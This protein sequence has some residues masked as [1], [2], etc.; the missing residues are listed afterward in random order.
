MFSNFGLGG[1]GGQQQ[2]YQQ[3]PYYQQPSVAMAMPMP[4][5]QPFSSQWGMPQQTRALSSVE[6]KESIDTWFNSTKAMIRAIP[7]Y[8]RYMDL[9]WQ[10]HASDQNRGFED[11]QTDANLT[12][13]VQS[14]Q[15][16]ALIDLCCTTVPEIDIN[17]VRAE[18]TSLLWIYNYVREHYGV[19]RT[20]RQMMQKFGVLQRRSGERLN[21]FWTRFQG[22]YAEN[23]IRKNDEIKISDNTGKLITA[24]RDEQGERYRLSSDIVTCLYLAHPDLP[25]EVEKMLSGKLENQDVASLQKEIFVKANIILEQLDRNP[26][27]NRTQVSQN[28]QPPRPRGLSTRTYQRTQR[29]NGKTNQRP[30]KPEHYC[31]SCLRSQ[32]NKDQ[33]NSH[34]IKDCPYLSASDRAYLLSMYDRALKNRQLDPADRDTDVSA[35]FI[36]IVE[37]YYGLDTQINQVTNLHPEDLFQEPD[38]PSENVLQAIQ[39]IDVRA[40]VVRVSHKID[41]VT[42]RRVETCPSPS[43]DPSIQLHNGNGFVQ[44]KC[45]VD[46]G[47]TG[48][49]I[50]NEKFARS[51]NATVSRS[52]VRKANLADGTSVMTILG[53]TTVSGNYQGYEFHLNALVAKDGDP[54][55]L[56]MP[57][58]E[59][60]GLIINC[61]NKTITFRNGKTIKYRSLGINCDTC[62]KKD[63]N[64][65]SVQIRRTFF[66]TPKK[67]N[68][69]VP[70]EEIELKCI[71]NIPDGRYAIEPHQNSKLVSQPSEWITPKIVEVSD[72]TVRLSNE[73]LHLQTVA[74]NDKIAQASQLVTIDNIEPLSHQELQKQQRKQDPTYID[75]TVDPDQILPASITKQFL[76]LNKEY[77]EVFNS[78]LPR[79]NGKFG[80]VE[81]VINVPQSLPTSSRMKEV[82][83]YP[84][85]KLIEMQEK[86]DELEAK[87]AFARP[88]DV[89]IEVE[90]VNPSFLVAK[91]PASRGHRLV[92]AFGNLACHV[93]NPQPPMQSTDQVLRRLSSW[94]Y[95]ITA[96]I[97]Q[98]YHQ[99]SLAKESQ[100]YAGIAS[101]FK[102]LRVYQTAA[103]GMPGSEF[104]LSEL[105]A[106]LFGD[107][108]KQGTLEVLM[109]DLY[110]GADTSSQLLLNWKKVLQICKEADIKLGPTKVVISPASV[111]VLGWIW[112]NGILEIDPHASNRLQ[113]CKPPETAEG[114]RGWIG[115][116]RYMAP[117]IKDHGETL[118][119]LHKAIGAKSKSDKIEWTEDLKT[120]FENAQKALK[121]AKPLTMP[122]PGEQLYITTDA[123][124]TGLGAT[125]HRA[126]DRA[127]VKHFSKQLSADKKRW[128]P[129]E[130][131]ALAV[132]SSL[133]YFLPFIRES[134]CSPIIYTDSTPVVMA[135]KKMQRG[136][137]SAS[138]RVSTF[139]H[140]VLNQGADIRYLNGQS[141]VTADQA[142]R[143]SA[144]CQEEK[145]QVCRWIKDKEEQVVKQIEPVEIRSILAGNSPLPFTSKS[146]WRKRQIED[147]TLRKVALFL[148]LGS[149]PPKSKSME[150]V[151]RY[152]Q[153]QHKLYLST[154]NVL[155]APSV[156]EFTTKPRIVVPQEA[157]LTVIAIYHQQF[158]CLPM[159]PLKQLIRR[160]FFLFNLDELVSHYIESCL[161]CAARKDKKHIDMPMSS[162]TPPSSFGEHFA[163]DIISR[164]C[165]KILV[166]R[167]TATSHTWA[168]IVA[169]EQKDTLEEGLRYLFSQVRPPN[170]TRP[171]VCR[172]DNAA[173][174]KSLAEND[175]LRDIGIRLD[176]GLPN[177]KNSNPVAEKANQELHECIITVSSGKKITSTQLAHAVSLLNSKPRWSKLSA[178]ELWTGRDMITGES[179]TFNQEDIISR[180]NA[181][182]KQSHPD[183]SSP[184][185]D[186]QIG[187]IVFSNS[188]GNKLKARDKLIVREK[189]ENG[190]YQLDRVH[191][192]SGKITR[193]FLPARDLYKPVS[194]NLNIDPQEL[195]QIISEENQVN[196]QN[197][198]LHNEDAN[199]SKEVVKQ[200]NKE[201]C[202]H[203]KRR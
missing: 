126:K 91:K 82:P 183:I 108:R 171:S 177:N 114:L 78:D 33:A 84:R 8:T 70:G 148:K 125:L 146:Y 99:I 45:I 144:T 121:T 89:G 75:V 3:Q 112:R 81:A 130:L 44:E 39:D 56:G 31:S 141:N 136:E 37:A 201:S 135:Y 53:E 83:W 16:E 50:I 94:K 79:Y 73:S 172:V 11:H 182:R 51:I 80:R 29:N 14:T 34:F 57:G 98:A 187:D 137:F 87:G 85:T 178:V 100:K 153:Q 41:P 76:A 154:E 52:A 92:T 188:E 147:K 143:N 142:S 19:K 190:I 102:G 158:N 132:G 198:C 72:N 169:N 138:P 60:L 97:A 157:A 156:T 139:L 104:A 107:L 175:C 103:M 200:Q 64:L 65:Q 69:L 128:L 77:Q 30:R 163:T 38:G 58:A 68:V 49:L 95:L 181:R 127:V 196:D 63:L 46:T 170:A 20:G 32:S 184:L 105:T 48:E 6:T 149:K 21:A 109:D 42:L 62:S 155:M 4:M 22:F 1:H 17:Y 12:A 160:H 113:N 66:Q 36:D 43:F 115:A 9:N 101:P 61:D 116:F 167:E 71:E 35:R 93:K 193:A 86:I 150:G 7:V 55:L 67:Q 59:K 27:V 123:S 199:T 152:L 122:K 24:N 10:S 119:P 174:F 203:K 189:L 18:A 194:M 180:Q 131:E 145:C 47:C 159:T 197:S 186:F 110:I 173:A 151:R 179:L 161:T 134:G 54:L 106:L 96:D 28:Y 164:Y 168:K 166:L 165:Q 124:Q 195:P 176:K 133:H 90:V 2:P 26:S 129:C 120:A 40:D 192:N 25:S 118:D 185:P 88:Q 74:R 5:S 13:R 191:Q 202:L 15:V 117:A 140:E 111:K 162:V 23:R